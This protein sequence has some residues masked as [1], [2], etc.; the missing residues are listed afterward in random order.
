MKLETLDLGAWDY[1]QGYPGQ[2]R[3]PVETEQ[4]GNDIVL[5]AQGVPSASRNFMKVR[6]L[7]RETAN[8]SLNT[9]E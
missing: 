6:L 3:S 2:G 4:F 5:S 7:R 8:L 1:P 9:E